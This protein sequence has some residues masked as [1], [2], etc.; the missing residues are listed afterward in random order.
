MLPV[1]GVVEADYI[2]S[3]H[4]DARRELVDARVLSSVLRNEGLEFTGNGEQF[5][6]SDM[7]HGAAGRLES[8]L[9]NVVTLFFLLHGGEDEGA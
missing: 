3:R 6:P 1:H 2:S 7:H 8:G 4:Y 5:L 9:A